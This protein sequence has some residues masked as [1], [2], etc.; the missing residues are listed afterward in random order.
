M[1]RLEYS[2][3]A[4]H[5]VQVP[6]LVSQLEGG[7]NDWNDLGFGL[8][9]SGACA[10]SVAIRH[11]AWIEIVEEWCFGITHGRRG[12]VIWV[13][14]SAG[15]RGGAPVFYSQCR[16]PVSLISWAKNCGL[17][18]ELDAVNWHPW[19]FHPQK[20]AHLWLFAKYSTVIDFMIVVARYSTLTMHGDRASTDEHF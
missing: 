14:E 17:W 6:P 19:L 20:K 3:S 16:G 9:A 8:L 12:S 7:N 5:T 4:C 15:L 18:K 2:A 13:V 10:H 11:I 1:R